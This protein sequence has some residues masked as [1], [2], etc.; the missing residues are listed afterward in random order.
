MCCTGKRTLMR[1]SGT[2][3][4][5]PPR[6]GAAPPRASSAVN[7]MPNVASGALGAQG[8]GTASGGRSRLP[9]SRTWRG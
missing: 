5:E 6:S 9:F 8:V 7:L 1:T 2:F 4:P 3:R